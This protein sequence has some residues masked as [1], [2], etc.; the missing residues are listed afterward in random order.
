MYGERRG[1]QDKNV[2]PE[3]KRKARVEAINVSNINQEQISLSF[4]AEMD[5]LMEFPSYLEADMTFP[6]VPESLMPRKNN[7]ID[8]SIDYL[9]ENI[10]GET[11]LL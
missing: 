4:N 7:Q 1:V 8:N 3:E 9:S 11:G 10:Q 6:D 2:L 5:S